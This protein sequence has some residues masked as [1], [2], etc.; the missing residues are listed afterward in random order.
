MLLHP[1]YINCRLNKVEIT[2][3][4]GAR[5]TMIN[6]DLRFKIDKLKLILLLR[7]LFLF[8]GY[9]RLKSSANMKVNGF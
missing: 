8:L 5:A 9:A 4:I 1:W 6:K 3:M 7:K 2:L